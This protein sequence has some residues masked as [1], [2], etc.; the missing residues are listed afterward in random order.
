VPL[1]VGLALTAFHDVR[2][3]IARLK[4]AYESQTFSDRFYELA[5][6]CISEIYGSLTPKDFKSLS[7][8]R[9]C[10][11]QENVIFDLI[12]SRSDSP[13]AR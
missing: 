11:I 6:R 1:L 10:C 12:G 7:G 3:E 5:S 2:I 4:E 13:K 8:M 9:V